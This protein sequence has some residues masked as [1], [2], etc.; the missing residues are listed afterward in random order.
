VAVGTAVWE[1]PLA[2]G[3]KESASL[4]PVS[5]RAA[6]TGTRKRAIRR[7]NL[8]LWVIRGPFLVSHWEDTVVASGEGT[9]LGTTEAAAHRQ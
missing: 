9:S 1:E 6:T 8:K 4:H 2:L 3:L 7:D 5:I